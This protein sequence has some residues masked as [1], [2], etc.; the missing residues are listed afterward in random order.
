MDK[1]SFANHVFNYVHLLG[2]YLNKKPS[3]LKLDEN[4][5]NFYLKLSKHHSLTVVFYKALI[6]TKTDVN[7][8]YL[9]KLE[10]Y[11]FANV[12]KLALFEKERKEL[13]K[14]LN[15]NQID[16]LPLKGIVL[17]DYYLDKHTREFADNDILFAADKDKLI[18][19]FFVNRGYKTESF[20]KSNHDVYLK[21]PFY[22]FEMHRALFS[23]REDIPL[24]A[25][26]FENY[27]K[28]SPI[29]DGYEHHLNNEDFYIYFTA[30]TYKHFQNSGCGIRTLID[31]YLYLKN[32]D[33]DFA[34]IDQELEKLEL[35]D[36]SHQ[37]IALSQKIFDNAELNEEEKEMLL[38]IASSGTYGT[39]EHSV[40]KGVNKKGRFKYFMQRVF[41]PMS[42]YKTNYPFMYKTKVL[43]PLAWL[44]RFFRILFK[45]PGRAAKELKMISKTKKDKKSD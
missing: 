30:H 27:I 20:R 12:R 18:K 11:Y 6:D 24:Y 14:Y 13:Y 2:S 45:N 43:I 15:N 1:E 29:K 36:F 7:P 23:K 35:K 28:D 22:N 26:Y 8:E 25:H 40:K 32:N 37:I 19:D 16:F 10:E 5:F 42:F 39:L 21:K 17:K 31:Y 34:Y 33:L 41:P 9:K 4:T 3:D 44:I 38:Y